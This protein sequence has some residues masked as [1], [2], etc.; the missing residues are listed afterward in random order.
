M[1]TALGD[2]PVLGALRQCRNTLT[3]WTG[4]DEAGV[5]IEVKSQAWVEGTA[6][7]PAR[8]PT[9]NR[10]MKWENGRPVGVLL[11]GRKR[12]RRGRKA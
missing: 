8:I 12:R 2:L 6:V 7:R 4:V 11:L 10:I 1:R 9:S 5:V 3:G